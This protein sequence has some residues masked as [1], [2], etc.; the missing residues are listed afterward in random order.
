MRDNPASAAAVHSEEP[1]TIVIQQSAGRGWLFRALVLAL[2]MS[3][4]FNLVLYAS[5]G[6]YFGTTQGPQEKY[7]AGDKLTNDRIALVEISGTISPPFTGQ[8]IQ[9]IEKAREDDNVKGVVLAID[10]P[11]GLV[12]DSHMIYHE[13][14]RLREKKPVAVIMKR[15]AASG[16]YYVAM[17]AGP[18]GKI[19]AEPTTWTGSIGVI[20]P[21][22]NLTGLADKVG[23]RI[24]PL[25]TGELKDALSPFRELTDRE[26]EVW[27]AIMDEAFEQ[28]IAVID[29]NRA[30]LD[31]EQIKQL[32]T[33]QIYTA[34]QA[35]Q[36]KL[37]DAIGFEEDAVAHLQQQLGLEKVRV[38]RYETPPSLLDLLTG[39]AEAQRPETQWQAMLELTVPRAMYYCSWLPEMGGLSRTRSGD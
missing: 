5:Y 9:A 10:S 4:L 26:R 24:E 7:H 32:A 3:L 28:F 16:G 23:V 18:D 1:R 6:E 14:E 33:G 8:I 30:P 11:G 27:T 36:A 35:L 12:A 22:Y 37:I 31:R 13:L 15:L 2:S 20:I 17:G 25:K 38:V 19:F 34:K 39:A 29:T 21:H